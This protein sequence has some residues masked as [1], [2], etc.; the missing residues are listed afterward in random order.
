M[1]SKQLLT[2]GTKRCL[3]ISVVFVLIV[4]LAGLVSADN[5]S[6][7]TE[8]SP[9]W[10]GT[11]PDDAYYL[12]FGTTEWESFYTEGADNW[13]YT[14]TSIQGTLIFEMI[15]DKDDGDDL[16]IHIYDEDLNFK[17]SSI[18]DGNA[19][20]K[21][22]FS[23]TNSNNEKFYI[24]VTPWIIEGAYSSGDIKT[25]GTCSSF[26]NYYCDG[27]E[28]WKYGQ[29]SSC[30]TF[31]TLDK[32]CDDYD[33]PGSWSSIQ[34]IAGDLKRYK[35]VTNGFCVSST[36]KCDKTS[37][38]T[39]QTVEE[40][41]Y[42]CTTGGSECYECNLDSQCGYGEKCSNHECIPKTCS[43]YSG[44]AGSCGYWDWFYG[45]S[46]CSNNNPTKCSSFEN[47]YCW[48]YIDYCTS[49]E[50]CN[51]NGI[52]DSICT[53]YPCT[54]SSV[55]WDKTNALIDENVGITVQGSHC[56][57]SDLVGF[58]IYEDDAGFKDEKAVNNPSSKYFSNNLIT[59][60]WVS[61]Y[62][63][64]INGDPEFAAY[65]Y[66]SGQEKKS[67][68][69]LTVSCP[70]VDGDDY[71]TYG[72]VC[73]L[74]D[75]NDNN[76]NIYPGA[77]EICN[78][79][80]D[81]C[82]GSSDE[83]F[84]L[85]N[86]KNNCGGCGNV[87]QSGYVCSSGNCKG[88]GDHICST[89]IGENPITCSSDCYGNLTI[90]QI[91]SAP[92]NVKQGQQVTVQVKIENKG[93]YS[94]TLSVEA[95]IVPDTWEGKAFTAEASEFGIQSSI[96]TE[97][98]CP[99]NNYYVAKNVTLNSGQSEYVSF[100]LYAPIP[101]SVDAC[102][103]L[104]SVWSSNTHKLVIGVYEK[105][106]SGYLD[107]KV[108]NLKVYKICNY[109][110][111]CPGEYCNFS[112][113][114]PGICKPKTCT[115]LCLISGSYLCSGTELVQCLDTNADGCLDLKHIADCTGTSICMPG[116]STCQNTAP[117]TKAQIEYAGLSTTVN[118]QKGDIVKLRLL[119][120]G[121][122]TITLSYD[123]SLFTLINCQNSFTITSDK[124]CLF[125]VIG[126]A[127]KNPYN[128]GINNGQQGKVRIITNPSTV[129]ITDRKK[130]LERYPDKDEV[131][132]MLKQAYST[133]ESQNGIV[134]DVSDY[135][136]NNLWTKPTEYDGGAYAIR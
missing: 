16:D 90:T 41:D 17:C 82:D 84:D 15:N 50:F 114:Y 107:S 130:L 4:I 67:S 101:S 5:Y 54:I 125:E 47:I 2:L 118:K 131:N 76:K 72:G 115:N 113:G 80:D 102:N 110:T 10:G 24:L 121:T 33:N 25:S 44:N 71:S 20:E 97:S 96:P 59:T 64:D 35:T 109:Q 99:A 14:T 52:Y 11:T 87:C 66:Y 74:I 91:T 46:D 77:T 12:Q 48:K 86:D 1:G 112:S 111:D 13:Y 62:F 32:D 81:D 108:Q 56:K 100:T 69:L 70:D 119:Y 88:C 27:D 105:C 92:T 7:K 134:Y 63:D 129:I 53:E 123:T 26:T 42:G 94:K 19:D 78:S 124:D 23:K 133:A 83:G 103:G 28:S 61:E 45:L 30:S 128:L 18:K 132:A 40:C 85:Q 89:E 43:D 9:Q 126:T 31:D 21:C 122:E 37:D 79:H 106:G 57:S 104:G 73:G 58:E 22:S 116:K 8:Y 6:T 98:C 34:C 3:E 135:L 120:Y 117:K 36:G 136:T 60:N 68:N 93:T 49:E 127:N 29:T 65:A 51:Q 95:G 39:Y 75:C 38:T 55:S